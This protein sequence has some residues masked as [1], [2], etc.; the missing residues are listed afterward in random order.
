MQR[1]IIKQPLLTPNPSPLSH[2]PHRPPSPRIN[3]RT[4]FVI[5]RRL[6]QRSING[7]C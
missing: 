2:S 3:V 7:R 5:N 6:R 1:Y 4:Q